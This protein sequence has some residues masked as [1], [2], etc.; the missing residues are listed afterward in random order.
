MSDQIFIHNRK[1][2]FGHYSRYAIY[3]QE[4]AG[5]RKKIIWD[6]ILCDGYWCI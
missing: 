5:V 4:K 2:Y 3:E 1:I 6:I